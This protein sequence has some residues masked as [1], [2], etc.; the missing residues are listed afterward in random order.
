MTVEAM[1]L[2]AEVRE[3]VE[4]RYSDHSVDVPT[5]GI[6]QPPFAT[7]HSL[8]FPKDSIV[9]V[10]I[11]TPHEPFGQQ[12]EL[13]PVLFDVFLAVTMSHK[14]G[15]WSLPIGLGLVHPLHVNE[16]L[17]RCSE[18]FDLPTL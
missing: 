1:S 12:V 8:S 17:E 9:A 4:S 11:D 16:L 10:M 18:L 14:H 15:P 6:D 7:T 3:S 5:V 2:D 13:L